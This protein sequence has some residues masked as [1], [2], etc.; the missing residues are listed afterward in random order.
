MGKTDCFT[1]FYPT[2]FTQWV[3]LPCQPCVWYEYIAIHELWTAS[4]H[5]NPRPAG[6]SGGRPVLAYSQLMLTVC[7]HIHA[8]LNVVWRIDDCDCNL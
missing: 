1:H 4:E 6:Y 7:D 2:G 3:K 5:A 8:C